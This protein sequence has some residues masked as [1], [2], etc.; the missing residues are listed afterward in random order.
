MIILDKCL[1]TSIWPINRTLKGNKS[2]GQS[3]P[4]RNAMKGYFVFYKAPGLE[5]YNP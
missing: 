3:R 1:N 5:P 4:G 2:P